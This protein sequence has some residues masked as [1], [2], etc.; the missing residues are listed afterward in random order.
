M[1]RRSD[2]IDQG[3]PRAK[4][5]A[6]CREGVRLRRGVYADGEE[7]PQSVYALRC[8]EALSSLAPGAAL[9]GPSAAF[10]LGLPLTAVPRDVYVRGIARGDYAGG[11]RALGGDADYTDIRGVPVTTPAWTVADCA[12]LMPPREGLIVADAVL[13]EGLCAKEDVALAVARAKGSRGIA[14]ARWVMANADPLAESP[15]E[16]WTRMELG[17]LGYEPSCQFHVVE[18]DFEAYVDLMLPDGRIGL[19][20]DGLVKYRG[21]STEAT[22]NAVLKEKVRQGSLEALGYVILRVVWVQLSDPQ[23][24][25]RRIRSHGASPTR[26][27]QALRPFR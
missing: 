2:L 22:A 10:L 18:G 14:R 6:R 26:P 16:T 17:K 7:P 15:G 21:R 9:A 24:L 3:I 1:F 11:V 19:E 23:V 13:H 25:D 5:D 8:L 27:P 20:F 12:R 4:V